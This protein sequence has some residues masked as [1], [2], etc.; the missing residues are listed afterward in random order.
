MGGLEKFIYQVVRTEL[1]L[2]G[3]AQGRVGFS[4][5]GNGIFQEV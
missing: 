5:T 1:R 3:H 2:V 4:A